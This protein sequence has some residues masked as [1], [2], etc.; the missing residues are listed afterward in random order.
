MLHLLI[1]AVLCSI[2][3]TSIDT[4]K[5]KRDTIPIHFEGESLKPTD[6]SLNDLY[7]LSKEVYRSQKITLL[8]T[9]FFSRQS[10]A[11]ITEQR[12]RELNK[13]LVQEGAE[14]TEI[15]NES[16]NEGQ[17]LKLQQ[18]DRT[19]FCLL[20]IESAPY[21]KGSGAFYGSSRA[22]EPP[23]FDTLIYL[24]S[25]VPIR[26]S[27]KAYLAADTIPQVEQ[28][29]GNQFKHGLVHDEFKFL[30]DYKVQTHDLSE[31]CFLVP[32][33]EGM[34]EKQMV[35][36]QSDSS[37]LIWSKIPHKGIVAF[38]KAKAIAVPVIGS[39]IYRIGFIP[40]KQEKCYVI[41]LPKE[42]GII[43]ASIMRKDN[44]EIP[45][46]KVMGNSALAF[47]IINDPSDYT[48]NIKLLQ[49]DGRIL[50]KD[51][52]ELNKCLQDKKSDNSLEKNASL[53]GI[54]GFKSP[55]F[56]YRITEEILQNNLV[57]R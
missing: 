48:L 8:V 14:S 43:D 32:T 23:D 16:L 15:F 28:I 29:V 33:E 41:A 2:S 19:I 47:K 12:L 22:Y 4:A 57:T 37:G 24:S 35:I 53:R 54:D 5:V 13:L 31:F 26:L 7:G 10:Q 21:F 18:K 56:K 17:A 6:N 38:G 20:L 1:P 52:I 44:V 42:Y 3:S 36:Y 39:G 45:V 40:P 25:N 51:G 50:I 9:P 27:H 30:H 55:D 46:N 34:S 49:A 11:Q